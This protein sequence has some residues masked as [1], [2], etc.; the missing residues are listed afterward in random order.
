[1][2]ARRIPIVSAALLALGLAG[3][4]VG[5]VG[6]AGS[7]AL[8]APPSVRV[9][10]PLKIDGTGFP[11][12]TTVDVTL[13]VQ[14]GGSDAFSVKSN[15][16]GAIQISLTP[17]AAYVGVTPVKAT[18]GSICSATVTLTVLAAN[19]GAP[20]PAA[21]AATG[22]AAEATPRSSRAP[23][24]DTM[25]AN[26]ATPARW[27]PNAW[28]LALACIGLGLGSLLVARPTQRR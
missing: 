22:A 11:T 24:T 25:P 27:P 19:G 13:S 3:S 16:S 15:A 4:V 12:N 28:V 26:G 5:V 20:A 6:A 14:G 21:S 18:A 7:C 8:S 9:G 23:R 10:E 1:M 17:E 2:N